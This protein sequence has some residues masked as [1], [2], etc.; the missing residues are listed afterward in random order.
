ML[1]LSGVGEYRARTYI[2]AVDL[3][4][5]DSFSGSSLTYV[6]DYLYSAPSVW[7]DSSFGQGTFWKHFTMSTPPAYPSE[8]KKAPIFVDGG[9]LESGNESDSIDTIKALVIAGTNV[10]LVQ[11]IV[12]S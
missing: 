4:F 8:D 3:P 10:D 2:R 11:N 9:V 1:K 7:F 5:F 12:P 6:V